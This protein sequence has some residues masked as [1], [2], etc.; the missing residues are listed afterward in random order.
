MGEAKAKSKAKMQKNRFCFEEMQISFALLFDFTSKQKQILL[1]NAFC[2]QGK[3]HNFSGTLQN[4]PI[5]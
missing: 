1:K 4:C 5:N 2:F 3:K